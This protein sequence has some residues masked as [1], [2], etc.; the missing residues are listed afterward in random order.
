M[1]HVRAMRLFG[2]PQ[3]VWTTV[4][5]CL[6]VTHSAFAQQKVDFRHAPAH[7]LTLVSHP[8]DWQKTL[9]DETGALSY[10]YGPG[11]YARPLTTIRFRWDDL[12]A[13]KPRQFLA[14]PKVPVVTT[15]FPASRD[16]VTVQ[17]FA[18]TP[19]SHIQPD[20]LEQLTETVY[21]EGGYNGVWGWAPVLPDADPAFQNAAW[22]TNRPI[23]YRA[24]VDTGAHKRV[25]MGFAEPY[26]PAANT[27]LLELRVEGAETVTFDPMVQ[28]SQNTPSVAVF[29]AFDADGDGRI[30]IEVFPS[31]HS[32]DPNVFLSVFWVFPQNTSID[33][34]GLIRGE[35][36][37]QAEIYYDCANDFETASL[38]IRADLMRLTS[39]EPRDGLQLVVDTRRVLVFDEHVGLVRFNQEPF[40]VTSPPLA[41]AEKTETGWV[42][43]FPEGTAQADVMALH[44]MAFSE[45][46][47]SMPDVG[48]ALQNAEQYWR[49]HPVV[50]QNVIAVPDPS[51]QYLI[52]TSVRNMYQVR[53]VVDGFRQFQPGPTV[54]RGLWI[55]SL[56]LCGTGSLAAGDTDAMRDYLEAAVFTQHPDGRVRGIYPHLL[57]IETPI[58][59]SAASIYIRSTDDMEW[60]NARWTMLERA[61]R[62]IWGMRSSTLADP[63]AANYGLMPVAFVDGGIS[64]PTADYG[65]AFWAATAFEHASKMARWMGKEEAASEW[66][67][68]R[69][70]I[71][72]S[73]EPAI[74]R[75]LQEDASG[76]LF[77]PVGVGQKSPRLPQQGQFGLLWTSRI[78]GIFDGEFPKLAEAQR[79]NL[80]LFSRNQDEGLIV[81]AGWMEHAV[82]SWLS[83]TY[84]S[85]QLKYEGR[86]PALSTLYS[87]ANHAAPTG[88]WVEE[89]LVKT[90][91]D[92]TSGDMSNGE[93][94]GAFVTLARDLVAQERGDDLYL[95]PGVPADWLGA[96]MR[97]ALDQ[98]Y[99]E[100]GPVTLEA[101]V[102]VTGDT[103][104]VEVDPINGRKRNGKPVVV[105]D[106]IKEAGF[107]WTQ[108][109]A[110]PDRFEGK[111]GEPIHLVFSRKRP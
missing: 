73:L 32:P 91:G 17:T 15:R 14:D 13:I 107:Q 1:Y 38:G 8:D 62:W 101:N 60:A 89:Q 111:W 99:T 66:E 4:L 44:G 18:L 94:S 92:R 87:M 96:D 84:G 98:S 109:G 12:S 69:D 61:V 56:V 46:T 48:A 37:G 11:P 79:H 19:R 55:S 36:N 70:E 105:L 10:D 85:V 43:R 77:L 65:T 100:F 102:S 28:G 72:A 88:V 80:A 5:L 110:T 86:E 6:F 82:W 41:S 57:M 24:L 68:W 54:Y 27:R 67:G 26:K 40:I 39:P 50:P 53:D 64:E 49:T 2:Y 81:S 30:R 51:I 35:M 95:L 29:D 47:I 34:Q 31:D 16:S 45:P 97:T 104:V 58:F 59:V 7:Y 23:L 20:P 25:V 3:W 33:E 90:Q 71:A 9:V 106:A 108:A 21:R 103:L 76:N 78:G 52:D 22:G 93:T 63:Q 83:G 42:F 74:G 75:D